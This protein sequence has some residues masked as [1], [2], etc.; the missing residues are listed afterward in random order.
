MAILFP[1]LSLCSSRLDAVTR[2]WRLDGSPLLAA[3]TTTTA[4]TPPAH[5]HNSNPSL[6]DTAAG[7][8]AA[9]QSSAKASEVWDGE[10]P[11]ASPP[12]SARTTPTYRGTAQNDVPPRTGTAG[13]NAAVVPAPSTPQSGAAWTRRVV[14]ATRR[15]RCGGGT[16]KGASPSHPF[17]PRPAASRHSPSAA[18]RRRRRVRRGR[19]AAVDH[20]Q[21]AVATARGS[22][23]T[24][25][26]SRTTRDACRS[27][28]PAS[29]PP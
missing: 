1:R 3:V 24:A 2:C 14:D 6:R 10:Q 27:T 21:L 7:V 11:A 28:A 8:V 5:Q 16:K 17:A 15:W 18:T 22:P 4:T 12:P 25:T 26:G 20:H 9:T 23:R 19:R 13:A 29:P